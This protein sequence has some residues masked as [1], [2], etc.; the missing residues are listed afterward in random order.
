MLEREGRL[1]LA[2][3]C[4]AFLPIRVRLDLRGW[5]DTD[6]FAHG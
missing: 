2:T 5:A 1:G 6:I 3:E 4:F